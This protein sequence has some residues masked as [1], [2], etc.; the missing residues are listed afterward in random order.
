M[1]LLS[2]GKC[3]HQ[4]LILPHCLH[5]GDL[6]HLIQGCREPWWGDNHP[7]AGGQLLAGGG[8]AVR[9]PAPLQ[10]MAAA[11]LQANSC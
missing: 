8:G 11:S 7:L 1:P 6:G 9:V 4:A 5:I 3:V 10:S 2:P